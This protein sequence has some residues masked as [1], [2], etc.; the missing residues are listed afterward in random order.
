[1]QMANDEMSEKTRQARD[2][3]RQTLNKNPDLKKAFKE[4]LDEASKPQNVTKLSNNICNVLA[5]VQKLAKQD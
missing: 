5:T 1:M 2:A 3:L 4:A